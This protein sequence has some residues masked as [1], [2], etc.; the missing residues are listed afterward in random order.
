MAAQQPKLMPQIWQTFA[1]NVQRVIGCLLPLISAAILPA[2]QLLPVDN[3]SGNVPNHLLKSEMIT[4]RAATINGDT[5]RNDGANAS[6]NAD[7]ATALPPASELPKPADAAAASINTDPLTPNT[8]P[9]ITAQTDVHPN[10][11]GYYPISTGASAFAARRILTAMA[12]QTIDIQYYIWHNDEAGQLMLKDLWLAAERGVI[13]RLLLDDF[14]GSNKLDALLANFARHP[15][16]AVRVINPAA[17]RHFRP[18]NFVINPIRTNTRMHNKSMIFDNKLAIIGGRNIGNEYL[19]RADNTH[20]AD[21]DVLLIGNVVSNI[22]Q[23]FD[24][25]WRSDASVDIETLT[26]PTPDTDFL[27]TLNLVDTHNN[28]SD[29]EERQTLARYQSALENSTIGQDL[30]DKKLAFRWAMMDFLADDADKLR[31]ISDT[32]GH[33]I[34]KL[35]PIFGMPKQTLTIISSY[36]V[37]TRAGV[38][39]L[40][41]LASSGVTVQILTNSYDA[42][43]VGA[44]H[45]G[46]AHWR[47]DLLAAGVIL[48]ELKSTA[49]QDNK[50]GNKKDNKTNNRLWR[51]KNQTTTSLHAK[52][53]AVDF[54]K[55]FIGSYN[56]DPRSANINTELGVV[57]YD[58]RL[59]ARLHNAFGDEMMQ[60]AYKVVLNGGKLE[61]HTIE[62]GKLAIYKQEPQMQAGDKLVIWLM[63]LLPID[64]LL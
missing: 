9:T 7:D 59:A 10:L 52:A 49:K 13:V 15:N 32:S 34:N 26:N 56:L 27:T 62:N 28:L 35:K 37:P 58:D 25:Y 14:N 41:E 24:E 16:I 57:I 23:S 22:R 18:V 38:K 39:N 4:A 3:T 53:F 51:T 29:D 31:P 11:S 50:T 1:P 21:L 64:W 5:K 17:I 61:W 46:Y 30:L 42:T 33:L 54:D 60:Q 8:Y 36:F 40:T 45:S 19:S 47:R 20:F 12:G 63:G 2:C 48:Y 55:V 43:D 44:V 6:H